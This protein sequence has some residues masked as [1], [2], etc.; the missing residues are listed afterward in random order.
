M[1]ATLAATA[2]AAQAPLTAM[3]VEGRSTDT[4]ATGQT[5]TA[6]GMQAMNDATAA[7]VIGALHT[8]FAGQAVQF[9]LREVRNERVS[10]RDIALQG[11]GE[12]Q[13]AE[14]TAWLPVS[15]SA[16]YDTA[17]QLVGSPAIVLGAG[18]PPSN[19]RDLPLRGLQ[20]RLG[21]K[22]S[23]EFSSQAVVFNLEHASIVGGDGRRVI[24]NGNGVARFDQ[25]DSAP[26]QV[27][28]VYD[29][30]TKQWI[31]ASYEFAVVDDADL[32]AVR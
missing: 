2:I 9:R 26:V 18:T 16:L 21:R 25:E 24:I 22:M 17:T 12:I 29:R 8:R 1:F 14:S 3:A 20:A 23:A 11:T 27:Q 31:D 6:H 10:L 4:S 19:A 7:A 32:V 30:K 5:T 28:A 13:F 15:F